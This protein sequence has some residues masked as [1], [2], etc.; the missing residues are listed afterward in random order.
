MSG[1]INSQVDK[2]FRHGVAHFQSRDLGVPDEPPDLSAAMKRA[3]N[4]LKDPTQTSLQHVYLYLAYSEQS[5]SNKIH[6]AG[7]RTR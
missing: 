2:F 7:G 3:R 1:L 6:I 5:D 4:A